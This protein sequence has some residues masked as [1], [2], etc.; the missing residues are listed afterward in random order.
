MKQHDTESRPRIN[1]E[2]SILLKLGGG[3]RAPRIFVNAPDLLT[4]NRLE[5]IA[6][7]LLEGLRDALAPEEDSR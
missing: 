1:P 5:R 3:G 4:A 7:E 2:P 6:H